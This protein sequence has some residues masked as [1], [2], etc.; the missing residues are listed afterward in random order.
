LRID[1]THAALVGALISERVPAGVL[2][3]TRLAALPSFGQALLAAARRRRT[4]SG[5]LA[6]WTIGRPAALAGFH[7]LAL[8]SHPSVPQNFLTTDEA[9]AVR[10]IS[11][12]LAV[13]LGT[14][15]GAKKLTRAEAEQRIQTGKVPA[16]SI[17]APE[18]PGDE[19]FQRRLRKRVA[20]QD[21]L[22]ATTVANL[23]QFLLNVLAPKIPA[24]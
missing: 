2:H 24:D 21:A 14:R 6:I 22:A 23:P 20:Q 11:L 8:F 4:P 9:I 10:N 17:E 12:A 16:D 18:Q 15:S 3:G 5:H 13:A 1:R 7:Y 19:R